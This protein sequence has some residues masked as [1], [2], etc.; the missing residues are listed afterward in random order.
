MERSKVIF[1]VNGFK[2]IVVPSTVQYYGA[3]TRVDLIN[4]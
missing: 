1:F 4:A 3:V 2:Y